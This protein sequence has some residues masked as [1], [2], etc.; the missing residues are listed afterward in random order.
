MAGSTP[1][2]FSAKTTTGATFNS[3]DNK[4]KYWVIFVYDNKYLT[5]RSDYSLPAE[6]NATYEKF[7]KDVD[8]VGIINGNLD[9]HQE[10]DKLLA[11]AQI[12][13]K[14]IDNTDSFERQAQINENI[15]CTPAK[16]LI[17]PE[18]KVL[19]NGCGGHSDY[20]DFKLDSLKQHKLL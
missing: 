9:N 15:F 4:G 1:S 8:F 2:A 18:G 3:A 6:L 10:L 12:K 19:Y 20:L 14:Q 11:T 13:F 16:L 17:S 5:P 7:K